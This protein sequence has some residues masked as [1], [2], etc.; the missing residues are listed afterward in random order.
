MTLYNNNDFYTHFFNATIV[1]T[2]DSKLIEMIDS[3]KNI[4]TVENK[5][6]TIETDYIEKINELKQMKDIKNF[7]TIY[8]KMKSLELIQKELEIIRLVSKYSLQNNKLEFDFIISCLKFL[9]QLSELL[10]IRLKQPIITISNTN[11]TGIVRCSY[12]FCNFKDSCVYNYSKKGN[13][14]YQDHYVHNMVSGDLRVLL[15]YIEQK[16]GEIKIVYHNKE[17]LKTI[18]T[19]SFV[20]NHMENELKAKCMYLSE[21]EIESFH[22]VKSKQ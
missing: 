21:N 9:F 3:T 18:N 20:I 14:C 15:D 10:R 13:C 17:I 22:F 5:I 2:I 11:N 19:L 7:N 1:D 4:T 12:K 6:D 16:Y 8:S